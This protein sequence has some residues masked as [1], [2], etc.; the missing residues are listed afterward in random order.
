MK[1]H[2]YKPLFQTCER[3]LNKEKKEKRIYIANSLHCEEEEKEKKMKR[4]LTT[5]LTVYPPPP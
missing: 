1:V 4:K 3:L 5:F 2:V